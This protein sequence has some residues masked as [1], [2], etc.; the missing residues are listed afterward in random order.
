MDIT[1]AA[2]ALGKL[3]GEQPL[4]VSELFTAHKYH[5]HEQCGARAK[6]LIFGEPRCT[7]HTPRLWR[8]SENELRKGSGDEK[9]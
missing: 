3:G 5:K 7:R 8:T 1:K 9:A 6:Y 4:C 2:A